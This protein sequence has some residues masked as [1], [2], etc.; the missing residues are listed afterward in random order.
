MTLDECGALS[1]QLYQFIAECLKES[2]DDGSARSQ[3]ARMMST[4]AIEHGISQRVL[5]ALGN[6]TSAVALLR[7][8]FETVTRGLWFYFA[9]TDHRVNKLAEL[10]DG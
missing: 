8:Q 4:I 3:L 10:I 1:D 5:L 7:V 2:E 6:V 9:A